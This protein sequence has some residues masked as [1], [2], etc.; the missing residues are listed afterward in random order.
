MAESEAT[1]ELKNGWKL[2][3]P[4]AGFCLVWWRLNKSGLLG[5]LAEAAGQTIKAEIISPSTR[6]D[7]NKLFA[8]IESCDYKAFNPPFRI[9]GDPQ[10]NMYQGAIATHAKRY[11]E[12]GVMSEYLFCDKESYARAMVFFGHLAEQVEGK[13]AVS[14]R[15]VEDGELPPKYTYFS[16][17]KKGRSYC[18]IYPAFA[19][20]ES[21]PETVI[22]IDGADQFQAELRRDFLQRWNKAG[23]SVARS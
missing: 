3:G 20:T 14:L 19:Y 15:L 18:I 2:G 13:L 10:T 17:R 21:L 6:E 16:G 12:G 8:G 22:C 5:R 11:M 1:I 4:F 23:P 9:E 7:Y